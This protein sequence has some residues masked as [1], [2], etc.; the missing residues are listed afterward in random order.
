MVMGTSCIYAVLRGES[1]DSR[2][3]GLKVNPP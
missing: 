3:R 1:E 2:L